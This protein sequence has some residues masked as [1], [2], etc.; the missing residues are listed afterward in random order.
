[1]MKMDVI[2]EMIKLNKPNVSRGGG[3]QILGFSMT[4]IP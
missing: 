3:E 2:D 4:N 1:M